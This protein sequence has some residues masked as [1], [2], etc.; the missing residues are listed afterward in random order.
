MNVL[1]RDKQLLIL[2]LICRDNGIADIAE[3]TDC[4]T[5][6]V[7]HYLAY[8]GEAFCAAH[9]RLVRVIKPTRIEADELWSYVYTKRERN[10]RKRDWNVSEGPRRNFP[11]AERGAFFTWTALDPDSK[12][13]IS[14]H[15]GDRGFDTG[16]EFFKD[17]RSRV[18]GRPMITTDA[19]HAY[20]DLIER[21]FGDVDHVM[22][23]KRIKSWRDPRTGE[24]GNKLI[25]ITKETRGYS[26]VDLRLAS[27]SHVERMNATI[28]NFNTRFTRQGY[29]FS[30]RF[31]NHLHAIAIG[32]FYYNFSRRHHGLKGS[33][34]H[35]T[36]AMKAGISSKIWTFGDMLDEAD[37]YWARKAIRAPLTLASAPIYVPLAVGATSP[38]PYFV[39]HSEG[40]R[41]AKV[42]KGACRN[43]QQ[44]M[45]RMQGGAGSNKW[46][47]F[48][49]QEEAEGCAMGLA[50]LAY[51]VCSICVV[52]KY[53]GNSVRQ[54]NEHRQ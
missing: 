22:L 11:P 23:Q 28:R 4:S 35:F 18:P 7:R 3:I 30:K 25:S 31:A 1:E 41:E 15:T 36:P 10:L 5:T 12:L 34:R 46:Y 17:L 21:T 16:L 6:T 45:G 42:H 39:M 27:T 52:G 32:M 50:P 33:Y 51:S 20:P 43:C 49:T 29:K 47:A 19:Y 9:D 24:S 2:K 26:K 40:K 48:Q 44:G 53:A 38:L 13:L 8:F 37:A 54:R 14:Y